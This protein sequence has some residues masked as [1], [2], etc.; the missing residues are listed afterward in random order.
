MAWTIPKTTDPSLRVGDRGI[1]VWSLQK[2]LNAQ[3]TD[4]A[5]DGDFGPAT[6]NSVK[7]TQR[8]L[9]LIADGI[10]GPRTQAGLV[11]LILH[12]LE[13]TVPPN[14]LRGFSEMEGGN[15]LGAVNWSVVGGVDSGVFQ[16]RVYEADYGDDAVIQRAFDTAYQG[17][18]LRDRL[19]ELRSIFEPRT[20]TRDGY[21]GMSPRE[22]AWRLACLNH[23]YPS[24]ADR[25]S[26][27]PIHQLASY[28]TTPQTWVTGFD[29]RFPDGTAV[30]TPLEWC[31]LYSGVL[32]GKHGHKGN[33]TRYVT[34]WA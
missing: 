1:V 33:V 13:G 17:R 16:R 31:H 26:R 15:L 4:V 23:N 12:P 19:V 8:A 11:S 2:A 29:F 14:L 34:S 9:G 20:G 27:T 7:V 28:W 32:A 30:R 3:N 10:A 21:G 24:A 18:L 5:L 25:F 22:K 6:E